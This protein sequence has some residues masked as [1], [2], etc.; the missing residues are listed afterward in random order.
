MISTQEALTQV[1]KIKK[2]LG[3]QQAFV[4]GSVAC[5]QQHELS[6][7]DVIFVQ[8]THK[9]FH[10]RIGDV[11]D[12]SPIDFPIEPLVYTPDEFMR[13]Q[14]SPALKHMLEGSIRV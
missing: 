7:V 10:H 14:T 8:E 11:L 1:R 2:Q 13:L 5:N 9:R 4:F 3:A 12:L 6:D